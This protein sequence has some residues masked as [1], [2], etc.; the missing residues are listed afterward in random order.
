MIREAR[1]GLIV[2]LDE[3]IAVGTLQKIIDAYNLDKEAHIIANEKYLY[4]P[5]AISSFTSTY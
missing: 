5:W 1:D 3:N 2:V 4:H